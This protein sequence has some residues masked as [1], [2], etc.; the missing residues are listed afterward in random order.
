M[1]E[2]LPI[3]F[4]E[5]RMNDLLRTEGGPSNP[6]KWILSND[7][8]VIKS[9][10]I[11]NSLNVI[12]EEFI[13]RED[14]SFVPR[15][16]KVEILEGAKAKSHKKE[17]SNFFRVSED[18]GEVGLEGDNKLLIKIDSISS[19]ANI[20]TR[21]SQY[22]KSSY[23]LSAIEQIDHFIPEIKTSIANN[24]HKIRLF[25]YSSYETNRVVKQYVI[26]RLNDKNIDFSEVKYTKD[27]C[28]FKVKNITE[29]QLGLIKS[30]PIRSMFP[31]PKYDVNETLS[32]DSVGELTKLEFDKDKQYPKI[33]ILDSGIE[34]NIF[35]EDWIID[36][37]RF[38][39]D[40]DINTSHGTF[41]SGIVLYGDQL[42]NQEHSGINGCRLLDVPIISKDTDEDELIS[43]IRRAISN[44]RDIKVWNLSV[45]IKEEIKNESFS[46][47]AM[48]L[49]QIQD[50]F[51]V[52]ICKSA[53]NSN[54]F[55]AGFPKEK[56]N[57]PAESVRAL[58]VGSIQQN[59]DDVGFSKRDEPAPYT[60]IG[61][62]SSR[63]I[64][65]EVVHY[66]GDIWKD[67]KGDFVMKGVKS[68]TKDGKV[69]SDSGTSFSTPR[70]S[71]IV[72]GLD[73][74]IDEQF[75]ALTLKA[76]LIHSAN[77]GECSEMDSAEKLAQLGFGKPKNVKDILYRDQHEIT[78]ILRDTLDKSRYVDIMDFPFP[79]ELTDDGFFRGQVTVTLVYN[80][81]LSPDQGSEY[82]QSN[83]DIK[84]GTY[85][86]KVDRDMEK[87]N[88]LNPMGREGSKNILSQSLFSRKVDYSSENSFATERMLINFGDKYYPVKKYVIDLSELTPSNKEKYI[89]DEK[90]WYLKIT[91]LY[92][93]FIEKQAERNDEKLSMD[94]CAII[95]I[96]DPKR[97]I[98]VYSKTVQSLDYNN[99][100]HRDIDIRQ[101][102]SV[103]LEN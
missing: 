40:E 45:S 53:G 103:K 33:G 13:N 35:N 44:N 50:E 67:K 9:R 83:I 58:T 24:S 71:S 101:D 11:I 2:K 74:E 41:V 28:I 38:Y 84:L 31:M 102:V 88:I 57:T 27:V 52:I 6:P 16:I 39:L 96:K 7:E 46:D 17:V 77:Y 97:E 81:I 92:R 78:L 36:R 43:N 55:L 23:A 95:S 48:A 4:F 15:I 34:R 60:R 86:E 14:P 3:K 8:L 21:A 64:K 26:S 82:C 37:E 93:D 91:G 51:D 85:N 56:I 69:M 89:N 42:E 59:S 79:R 87:R 25:N 22:T 1:T 68:L 73:S 65:P 75:D 70:I 90:K 94:Y 30:L 100:Y 5:K 47:M 72:A 18:T 99:F 54:A 62:G 29:D 98:D 49:D 12:E 20:M 66:G 61:R 76:L 32:I 80:P 10:K 63:I 19:L